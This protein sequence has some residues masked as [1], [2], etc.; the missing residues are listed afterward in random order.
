MVLVDFS[1]NFL[2]SDNCKSGDIG[3]FLDEGKMN[4]RTSNN[5]KWNQL[6]ITVEVNQKQ[7]THSFKSAEGKKF[8][9]AYGNDTKNWIGKKF[10]VTFV[11]YIDE[12]KGTKEIKQA[13]EII[14]AE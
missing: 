12:S 6:S 9:T 7:Y 8:Q 5:K 14:P 1:G 13:V 2:N 4:E 11:P 10:K 3:F